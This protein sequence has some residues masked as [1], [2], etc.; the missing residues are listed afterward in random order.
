MQNSINKNPLKLRFVFCFGGLK[1]KT[2]FWF[3]FPQNKNNSFVL[4][5]F[6]DFTRFSFE[7]RQQ[8]F[9]V[10]QSNLYLWLLPLALVPVEDWGDVVTGAYTSPSIFITSHS[11]SCVIEYVCIALRHLCSGSFAICVHSKMSF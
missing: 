6:A 9:F 4:E 1:T 10:L 8:S 3:Y 2:F 11:K 7:P 5:C